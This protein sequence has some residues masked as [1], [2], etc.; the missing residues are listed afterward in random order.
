MAAQGRR[1]SGSASIQAPRSPRPHPIWGHARDFDRDQLRYVGQLARQYGDVVPLRLSPYRV[2]LFN[3]PD[4][5]EQILLTQQ[6]AFLKGWVVHR[7]GEVLGRGLLTSDGELWRSQ[8]RLIQPS[9]HQARIEE[10]G[11]QMAAHAEHL[12]DDW[13]D[14]EQ[15]EIQDDM[16]RLTLGVVCKTLFDLDLGD[17]L[18]ETGQAFAVA[19]EAVRGRASATQSAVASVAPMPGRVR[20]WR[21][22]RRLEALVERIVQERRATGDRGDLVSLLLAS[23]YEDGKP[24]SSR[25]VRDEIMTILLAGHET[26]TVGMTWAWYLLAQHPE[27]EARLHAECDA[28]LGDRLPTIAD[29]PRLAYTSQVVLEVL[30]LYPPIWALAREANQDVQIGG[31]QLK[32]GDVALCSQWAMHRDPRYYERPDRFEP[33][34]W[35]DGLEQR[36]PRFAYF[37]FSSGSRQCLGKAFSLM[38]M[39]LLLAT[40]A[41]RFRL[42]LVPGQT[43]EPRAG[44]TVRPV[45]GV[46]MV[47]H[48]R[49]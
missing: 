40:I 48:R 47:V 27:A 4:A 33:E 14:G 46:R 32:K 42:T 24:M 16:M 12:I 3:H 37:P 5:V 10:Y 8:R 43:V 6:R 34:R 39:T 20:L 44:V 7:L 49:R 23:R 22:M 18:T 38:E 28:V 15:R 9:F 11:A 19:I 35:T 36:L 1:S 21:A 13:Q 26:T 29:V 17:D 41:R 30:R 45:P 31:Y 2:V 25:Q